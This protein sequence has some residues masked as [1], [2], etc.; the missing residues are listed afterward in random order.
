MLSL[1]LNDDDGFEVVGS[2][3]VGWDV[4]GLA[5]GICVGGTV[6]D[7]GLL[8]VGLPDVSLDVGLEEVGLFDG[9]GVVGMLRITAIE[10]LGHT[11]L[12]DS[13]TVPGDRST[14]QEMSN[15]PELYAL[16]E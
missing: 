8:V 1:G 7:V 10:F 2:A 13:N 6:G 14:S 3:D 16:I 12:L 15:I 9:I 4:K 11:I 5:V